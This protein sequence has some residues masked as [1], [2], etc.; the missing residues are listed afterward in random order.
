MR[1][2]GRGAGWQRTAKWVVAVGC[3]SAA[4]VAAASGS[5]AINALIVGKVMNC[6]GPA[7]GRCFVQ[8]RAVVSVFDLRHRLVAT[9]S[10]TN[11]HFSFLLSPGRYALS[12]R[13][14]D[15]RS[16]RRSVTAKAHTR[17]HAKI[18]FHIH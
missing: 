14:S 7:P 8:R 4:L 10:I 15:G 2:L 12:A 16:A 3:L 6:G 13:T 1:K 5:A 18:V 11:G 9:E 17:V